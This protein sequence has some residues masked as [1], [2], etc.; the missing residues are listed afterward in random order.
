MHFVPQPVQ[1]LFVVEFFE[2]SLLIEVALFF[3]LLVVGLV[4]KLELLQT[5]LAVAFE[6]RVPLSTLA[7]TPVELLHLG[8]LLPGPPGLPHLLLL[9]LPFP[10]HLL[11]HLLQ[12]PAQPYYLLLLFDVP[13][14]Q[15]PALGQQ[16]ILLFLELEQIQ[17]VDGLG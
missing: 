5:L 3:V 2:D 6:F 4:F 11:L 1:L 13:S 9:L 8:V 16:L 14:S 15:L 10:P 17:V 7:N 12:T